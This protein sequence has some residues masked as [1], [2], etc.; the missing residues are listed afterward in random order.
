MQPLGPQAPTYVGTVGK[1]SQ[2]DINT[3]DDDFNGV[4]NE[5]LMLNALVNYEMGNYTLT[6][7]SAYT[8][9]EGSDD[10]DLDHLPTTYDLGETASNSFSWVDQDNQ[11]NYHNDVEFERTVYF[12]DF[13]LSFDAGNNIRW[14]LGAEY[15]YENYDN[16][17]FSRA[18][19][20][21]EH[22]TRTLL[23]D[24]PLFPF[25]GS[26]TAPVTYTAYI[27]YSEERETTSWGVYGSF[28][29]N[30]AESWEASLSARYQQEEYDV[31]YNPVTATKVTPQYDCDPAAPACVTRIRD[32]DDFNSFNPR[33][34]ISNF[35]TDKA[36]L[37]A[38]VA[39]G[40]KPGGYTFQSILTEENR[41]YDQE[42]LISY[43]L[44]WK[45]SWIN[46]RLIVNGA[47][48]Y[49]DNTDKQANTVQY[50]PID[51]PP[52]Y[53][54][55]TPVTYVDNIGESDVYGLELQ[56]SAVISEGLTANLSYAYVQTNIDK[57][58]SYNAQG[59]AYDPFSPI[60]NPIDP[61]AV[62][63]S[64]YW[65]NDLS[66]NELPQTPENQL[67]LTFN[68][69]WIISNDLD[70]FARWDTKYTDTRYVDLEN[71]LELDDVT[72]MDFQIGIRSESLEVL[73]YIT[74]F[75]D[76]DTT[77]NAVSFVNFTQNFERLVVAYP[78][79]KREGGVRLK[80]NF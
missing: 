52:G 29:W 47:L 5:L 45:T 35:V 53:Q 67:L 4:K 60:A 70:G 66:G 14:L 76:E 31:R 12:Q 50:E 68:Y 48:F 77:T 73:A 49:M 30:F 65:D 75:T 58:T 20:R 11:F 6:S 55:A 28:D 7:N 13:H 64:D 10:Y 33:L 63:A 25:P 1:V 59:V 74:N 26:P 2:S 72:T 41:K 16:K 51:G 21:V 62:P 78:T 79:T 57:Y 22:D 37:Y 71:T 27:P 69:D 56:V 46:D 42:K 61:D 44:G 3:S 43:E 9:A 34:V 19:S 38:S 17:N 18:N 80:W 23:V 40:T 24:E 15:Y 32:N 36:M 39:Q 8:D 54:V